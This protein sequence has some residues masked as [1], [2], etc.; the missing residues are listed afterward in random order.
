[1]RHHSAGYY[2]RVEY[3]DE[4]LRENPPEVP[5]VDRLLR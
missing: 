4:P 1:M 5:K 2:V 3:E